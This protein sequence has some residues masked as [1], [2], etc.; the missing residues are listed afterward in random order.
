M[1]IVVETQLSRKPE[2]RFAWPLYAAALHAR[3]RCAT[4]LVVIAPDDAVA[5]W[6]AEPIATLQLGS[7]FAPIVIDRARIPVLTSPAEA[8][9][10]PE[11][12][13]LS[14]L[15]HGR[16][17]GGIDI[18]RAALAMTASLLDD[19]KR[20]AIQRALRGDPKRGPR[21][22]GALVGLLGELLAAADGKIVD[23]EAWAYLAASR[24]RGKVK[25]L[26][27]RDEG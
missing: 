21:D 25:A 2:K 5:R 12:A 1:G 4:A 27:P 26:A 9:R 22:E 3:L 17:D 10:T 8:A 24:H 23:R 11:L 20:T 19:D 16:E 18:A 13:I 6:A 14:A 15:A 7:T